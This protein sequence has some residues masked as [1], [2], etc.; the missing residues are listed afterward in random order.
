MTDMTPGETGH[1]R[2]AAC[3]VLVLVAGF[4]ASCSADN[5]TNFASRVTRHA[6][7]VTAPPTPMPFP[8]TI[9][10]REGVNAWF[11]AVELAQGHS[12]DGEIDVARV[13]EIHHA[14]TNIP[15]VRSWRHISFWIDQPIHSRRYPEVGAIYL[16]PSES[17]RA[18]LMENSQ[19]T[20]AGW[21]EFVNGVTGIDALDRLARQCRGQIGF[22]QKD[23]TM[24]MVI[25]NR[26][27]DVEVMARQFSAI[28][29]IDAW[30][31]GFIVDG[32]KLTLD[33]R[34]DR[35][36][37]TFSRGWGDC[38]AGCIHR[39][40]YFASWDR[41][42]KTVIAAGFLADSELR[43]KRE[44]GNEWR[45]SLLWANAEGTQTHAVRTLD[46]IEAALQSDLPW[47][48]K[49][50]V[51]A[52]Y[53]GLHVDR[54]MYWPHN[55]LKQTIRGTPD[56]ARQLLRDAAEKHPDTE[57]RQLAKSLIEGPKP[58]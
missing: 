44:L 9:R 17:Y 28:N 7:R 46:D 8:W 14:L 18:I 38:T 6:S 35:W 37:F 54:H 13:E 39:K 23:A 52:L 31:N 33:E 30:P 5:R 15:A 22:G 25:F 10:S 45:D 3:A 50:M 11:D 47:L 29:G 53:Y 36:H 19:P 32:E 40:F 27:V 24:L 49:H 12:T 20:A 48:N 55:R 43:N 42:R 41:K 58:E 1:R 57:V 21:R 16:A 2:F 51:Q 26:M 4:L 34:G 56:R